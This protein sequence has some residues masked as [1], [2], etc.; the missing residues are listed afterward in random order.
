MDSVK[1]SIIMTTY[2]HARYVAQAI[3]SILLQEVGFQ[4]ELL[5]GDDDSTDAT[6]EI[7][8]KYASQY[9]DK[10]IP[11]IRK[12]NIGASRN[13]YDLLQRARGQYIAILEGDDLW[14]TS[15][16]LQKQVEY[17]DTHLKIAACVHE[18]LLI[19]RM[20]NALPCQK[21]AWVKSRPYFRLK[22]YDGLQ[23]PG[24]ISSLLFRKNLLMSKNMDK[25]LL[26]HMQISDRTIFLALLTKGEIYCSSQVMS[27]YRILREGE[28][29]NLTQTIYLS[30]RKNFFD[31]MALFS[32]MS[33]WLWSECGISKSFAMAKCGVV[34]SALWGRN[35]VTNDVPKYL[36]KLLKKSGCIGQILLYVPIVAL[37]KFFL[38]LI[39]IQR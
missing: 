13:F 10:I 15:G 26:S 32:N 7:L 33:D 2:N 35:R 12:E 31:E 21:L 30:Q 9:S 38:R 4:W 37:Q 24:H 39:K 8:R 18:A 1:V 22:D 6:A 36:L 11:I 25:L 34:L 17:L 16:K 5:I 14:I 29:D 23:L 3:D 27:A 19:D 28:D 20:G